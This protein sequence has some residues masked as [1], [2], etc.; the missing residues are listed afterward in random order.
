MVKNG[1]TIDEVLTESRKSE[2]ASRLAL[3]EYEQLP[4]TAQKAATRRKLEQAFNNA[5]EELDEDELALENFRETQM[6]HYGET[7]KSDYV[8]P[9]KMTHCEGT[10]LKGIELQ[11]WIWSCV[12]DSRF[13]RFQ[14]VFCNPEDYVVPAFTMVKG[15]LQFRK[16]TS[17]NTCSLDACIVSP[18]R[19]TDEHAEAFGLLE[20][21][22]SDVGYP[23]K[24]LHKKADIDVLLQLKKFGESWK[25]LDPQ[26]KHLWIVGTSLPEHDQRY[27]D[28]KIPQDVIGTII[29]I[30]GSADGE[31]NALG[32]EERVL[33]HFPNAFQ[34][35]RK[36]V[37]QRGGHDEEQDELTKMH[38]EL[39]AAN[40][41]L[42]AGD[43]R[44]T[45][46]ATK[47]LVIAESQKV[48]GS[49]ANALN[50]VR[51]KTKVEAKEK[52][53]EALPM[54]DRRGRRSTT[55][56]LSK[57]VAARRR[58]ETRND[59]INDMQ[60]IN[61]RDR[62]LLRE[63]LGKAQATL[64]SVRKHIVT[65]ARM[66]EGDARTLTAAEKGHARIAFN[67]A[68]HLQKVQLQPLVTHA[69]ILLKQSEHVHAALEAN[70]RRDAQAALLRMQIVGKLQGMRTCMEWMTSQIHDRFPDAKAKDK[71]EEMSEFLH[72]HQ[73][74]P[75]QYIPEYD[76]PYAQACELFEELVER[77]DELCDMPASGDKTLLI[78]QFKERKEDLDVESIV[79]GLPELAAAANRPQN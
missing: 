54:K 4:L 22:E 6:E 14:E 59:D 23:K 9:A 10:H 60:S 24:R 74:F 62:T 69:H 30:Q 16:I 27:G 53:E 52:L 57:M 73:I 46:Q 48:I 38:A 28:K 13:K 78:E 70:S 26:N 45:P 35:S 19:I 15:R 64:V 25:Q 8:Q 77:F 3:R 12:P 67:V 7:W 51:A 21:D 18:D 58:L 39:T 34:A 43:R 56:G 79:L 36:P 71:V 40:M 75:Q 72:E 50:G 41:R 2:E 5:F 44:D 68:P 37:H 76:G 20:F 17:F 32:S 42:D 29:F 47:A 66:L 63:A 31:K 61:E 33:S 55:A 1:L 65:Y 49:A 11:Q